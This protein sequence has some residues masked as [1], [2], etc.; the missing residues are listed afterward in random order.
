MTTPTKEQSLE[1]LIER[2]NARVEAM[3]PEEREAMWKAQRESW[4][5][6]MAPCEHGI[7]DW[8][9]CP[10]CRALFSLKDT[11]S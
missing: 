4:V 11:S 9:T 1:R 2:A 3:S 10:D 8:E 5:R 6:G 7:A